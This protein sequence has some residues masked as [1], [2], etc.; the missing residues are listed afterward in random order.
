MCAMV[1]PKFGAPD[2]FEEQNV[3]RPSPGPGEVLVRVVVAGARPTRCSSGV[4]T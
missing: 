3:E 2:L 4:S 1:M